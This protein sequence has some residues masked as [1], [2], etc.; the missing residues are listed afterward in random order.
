MKTNWHGYDGSQGERGYC[1]PYSFTPHLTAK[2][3]KQIEAEFL[4]TRR[5]PI[6]TTFDS[7]DVI[8]TREMREE[9]RKKT[10]KKR[11]GES[12]I[13]L[14]SQESKVVQIGLRLQIRIIWGG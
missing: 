6:C 10:P 1:Q 13:I 9:V 5:S 12:L 4:Q 11:D 2:N 8:K 3:Y 14:T 7:C